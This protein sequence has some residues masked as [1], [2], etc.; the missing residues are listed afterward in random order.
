MPHPSI[1]AV[2]FAICSRVYLIL[3]LINWMGGHYGG[4]AARSNFEGSH[5]RR[6]AQYLDEE[7]QGICGP[8]C[9]DT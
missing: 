3:A 8:G 9:L 5:T 7:A 1:A 6:L 4:Q 2:V